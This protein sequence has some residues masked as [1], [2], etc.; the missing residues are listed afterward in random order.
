MA[1]TSKHYYRATNLELEIWERRLEALIKFLDTIGKRVLPNLIQ[2]NSGTSA[3]YR[4]LTVWN[5]VQHLIHFGSGQ[6]SFFIESLRRQELVDLKELQER[7]LI[8][9]QTIDYPINQFLLSKTIDQIANDAATLHR[10]QEQR[11]VP[12]I[13]NADWKVPGDEAVIILRDTLEKADLIA[14]ASLDRFI[15]PETTWSLPFSTAFVLTYFQKTPNV[16]ILPYAPVALIGIPLTAVSVD[17]DLLTI[18]HELGHFLYWH[19]KNKSGKFYADL[20]TERLIG[21]SETREVYHWRE[22]IFAD[23]VS[24]LIAGPI[25]AYSMQDLSMESIGLEFDKDNGVHPPP[26]F[27]PFVHTITLNKL[28]NQLDNQGLLD[29]G[30]DL[31]KRWKKIRYTRNASDVQLKPQPASLVYAIQAEEQKS[32]TELSNITKMLG[33]TSKVISEVLSLF[34]TDRISRQ[35][36]QSEVQ[37]QLAW[38]ASFNIDAPYEEFQAR[39]RKGE[40]YPHNN[41]VKEFSDEATSGEQLWHQLAKERNFVDKVDLQSEI[42]PEVWLRILRFAG[43]TTEGPNIKGHG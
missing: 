13:T 32:T 29:A 16:R 27:R 17:E 15:G 9:F 2:E 8:G 26:A 11:I 43:W 10:L 28:G 37:A 33:E 6:M 7:E 24:V 1:V 30:R 38:T 23:V 12:P 42:P 22:E 18:P 31:W 34:D 3:Y 25:A 41:Y 4:Q 5:V 21:N 35:F 39:I 36:L 19:G 14:Q 40:L 20:L